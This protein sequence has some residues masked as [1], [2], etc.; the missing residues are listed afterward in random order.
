MR[1]PARRQVGELAQARIMLQGTTQAD[2]YRPAAAVVAAAENLP[3]AI[4][5]VTDAQDWRSARMH[6]IAHEGCCVD[7]AREGPR[8]EGVCVR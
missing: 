7:G 5:L 2:D 8:L 3:L 4:N 6:V 1:Y